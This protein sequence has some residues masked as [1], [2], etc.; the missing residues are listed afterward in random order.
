MNIAHYI[1]H[2][3]LKPDTTEDQIIQLCDEAKEH[4]FHSVCI[5]P[6]YLTLAKNELMDFPIATTTVIG[7]PIGYDHIQAKESSILKS[8]HSGADELDIVLNVSAV[9]SG[10][11]NYIRKEMHVYKS[12]AHE[13]RKTVKFILETGLLTNQEIIDLCGLCNDDPPD[14]VKTSTGFFGEGV[15][16][17]VIKLLRRNLKAN[18]K[19]K[20]S[21]G[22][23]DYTTA[24]QLIR[25]GAD[26]LGCSSSVAILKEASV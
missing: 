11:W 16:M 17:D 4:R 15:T 3:I 8:I 26:R 13:Y 23:K 12:L 1:D 18:L 6:Y 22:I 20:A 10:H 9:K 2:T 21:G 25:S 24:L 19:I 5:P 14:F 7:F